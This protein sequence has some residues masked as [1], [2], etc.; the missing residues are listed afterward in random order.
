MID[1]RLSLIPLLAVLLALAGCSPPIACS[2]EYIVN[3]T[4][5]TNDGVCNADDCSL[6]EAV[7]N[8]N[9]CAGWQTITLPAGGYALTLAGAEEDA[10][11][12]GDLDITDDVTIVGEGAPSIDGNGLDRI[13]EVFSPAVVR[14]ETMIL[15]GGEAQ[16][17]GA[18]RNHGTLTLDGLSIH[19]NLAVVPAGGVGASSGGGI[20]NET[21]SLTLLGTQVFENTG[22]EGGGIHNFATATL[23]M[24]GGLIGHNT[25]TDT[26]GGLWNNFAAEATLEDVELVGNTAVANGAGIYNAGHLEI[27]L[28]TFEENSDSNQGGGL[29][30]DTGAEAFL[31][32]AWF[33]N[34]SANLGGGVYNLG[35]LHLYR[36]S[37]TVN[38]AFGGFGG[39][40]YNLSP[41]A[42]LL[43]NVTLSGNMANP[44]VPGGAG[45]YN[46]GGEVRLEFDTLAYNSPDGVLNEGGGM[47]DMRSTVLAHHALGNCLG[48]GSAG[49]NL[50]D[51]V[52]C[53]LS[54]ASDLSGVDPLLAPLAINGGTNLSHALNPGSP[55]IDSGTPDLCTSE[56]QRGVPRPQGALC[57]RGSY[58]A[59]AGGSPTPVPELGT[60]TGRICYPSEGIPPMTAYF[61][62]AT[63]SALDTLDIGLNQGTYSIAL[64]P[65][66]YHA[67]AWLPD[68]TLGGAYTVAVPCGLTIACTDHSLLAFDV[69]PGAETGDIDICDWY[70]EPGSVPL[71]PDVSIITPTPVP[72]LAPAMAHFIQNANC[73]R[74]PGTHYFVTTSFLVDTEVALIG[75]SE[76][77]IPFWWLV[78]ENWNCWVSD[79]TMRR[80]GAVDLLP[81]VPGPPLP[82]AP[83]QLGIAREYC[84]PGQVFRVTLQWADAANNE[85]GYRVYREGSVLAT[86]PA[87][88]TTYTD[89]PPFGGPYTYSVEAVSVDG[90]SAQ[91]TVQSHACQ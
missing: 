54:E 30:N 49:F 68:F 40:A 74:G 37:L 83:T 46:S 42:L 56:D 80:L 10:A 51:G 58:E 73:R 82:A 11:A 61:E 3:K 20:F 48:V 38:T 44:A 90:A 76:P 75:R 39:G 72:T 77:G 26:A 55:A 89:S 85:T 7:R 2:D 65:G 66:T 19:G 21:G 36:S 50:E 47:V 22:D 52:S 34:N 6:R 84:V 16:L 41:G 67:Y 81:I 79:V 63:T 62:N 17:G 70:G 32:D 1:R 18:L 71:P 91:A 45:V 43:R 60:V 33:T 57:D 13:F 25:A 53:G 14:M 31:Y 59:E 64:P 29:Y 88:T 86:L 27:N 12:T 35:L 9:A 28:A 23:E 87:N 78:G 5:D 8:A 24:T 15:M 69:V 4:A